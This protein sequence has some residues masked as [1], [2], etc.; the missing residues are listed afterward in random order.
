[1]LSFGG[2]QVSPTNSAKFIDVVRVGKQTAPHEDGMLFWSAPKDA[3]EEGL[4]LMVE[5]W[6]ESALHIELS[7]LVSPVLTSANGL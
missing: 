3:Q 1:M 5:R 7:M 6:W 4:F 2:D